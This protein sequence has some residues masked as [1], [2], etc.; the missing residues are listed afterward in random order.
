MLPDRV[1]NPVPLTYESGA[2][3]I[4]ARLWFV[5]EG[6]NLRDVHAMANSVDPNQTVNLG[7]HFV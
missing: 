1:S 5:T 2:L 4:A 7:L 3:P 6:G